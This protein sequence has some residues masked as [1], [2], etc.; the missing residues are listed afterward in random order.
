[1]LLLNY[2]A[3]VHNVSIIK[4]SLRFH[5]NS[6]LKKFIQNL[7]CFSP[8]FRIFLTIPSF[9]CEMPLFFPRCFE[10][11]N[12][13]KDISQFTLWLFSSKMP[14]S[15]QFECKYLKLDCLALFAADD[16]S[17]F[18]LEEQKTW[19]CAVRGETYSCARPELRF[20]RIAENTICKLSS[21]DPSLAFAASFYF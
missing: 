4:I 15:P 3:S 7:K 1:M 11:R 6:S 18:F 21:S 8:N 12:L 9:G 17:E 5:L 19:F 2:F 14:S 13:E 16:P 10:L 20:W